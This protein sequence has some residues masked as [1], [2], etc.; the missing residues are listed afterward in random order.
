MRLLSCLILNIMNLYSL[1]SSPVDTSTIK[2]AAKSFM[3]RERNSY[4]DILNVV[5]EKDGTG[6]SFYV[7]NFKEGGWVMVSADNSIEPILGC[8]YEGIYCLNDNKPPAFVEW[9]DA[10]KSRISNVNKTTS[11][12][13]KI[14]MEWSNLLSNSSKKSVTTYTLN[15]QLLD[16]TGRGHVQWNQDRN[17][18]GSCEP[19][20]Y[21]NKFI[22]DLPG[23]GCI[24]D[25][26]EVGCGPVA[27]GQIMWYWEW[28]D[29]FH[30][31]LMPP[32]LTNT[33]LITEGDEVANFLLACG[34]ASMANYTL[35]CQGT[36]VYVNNVVSAF[37]NAFEFQ[38]VKKLL[39]NDWLYGDAW[40][41]LLR[42][43]IDAG[44]P[45]FYRGGSHEF[46]IDGYDPN[47]S[48]LFWFNFG[49]GLYG[50]SYNIVKLDINNIDTPNGN[51]N[52]IQQA[53]TGISPTYP[54]PTEENIYDV[55]Y[56]IISDTEEEEA[57]QNIALPAIEKT[58]TIMNSGN[59]S[60]KA[61]N[62]VTLN[63]GF[64]VDQGGESTIS[65]VEE[66]TQAHEIQV[67][68]FTNRLYPDTPGD[69]SVLGYIVENADSWEFEVH[70]LDGS[71]VFQNAGT[72]INNEA[73]VWDGSG[74]IQQNHT[75]TCTIRFK[76]NF[77]RELEHT[78]NVTVIYS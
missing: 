39:R 26:P 45:I 1:Y 76:N 41:K 51:F 71:N 29:E 36:P 2:I 61:G 32:M 10:F 16:I 74:G 54:F 34:L 77:G 47:N 13:L 59:L 56:S 25:K 35:L 31:D 17:Y 65:V 21:Y 73:W 50:V 42:S 20:A 48:N 15:N 63:P 9:K 46:V 6:I 12:D 57:Q 8:G 19:Y 7:A 64:E 22:P 69:D 55:N 53:I 30:W 38:H 27:M 23:I 33:T 4:N 28:P 37:K 5:C 60:L 3:D 62:S 40:I 75:Y 24:C 49:W 78:Y 66:M 67:V 72:V 43:E 11:T 14:E 70:D 18:Y 58:L 52:S 68:N 44:R